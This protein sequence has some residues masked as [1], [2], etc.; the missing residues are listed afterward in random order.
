M[1]AK[2]TLRAALMMAH[3]DVTAECNADRKNGTSR[4]VGMVVCAK[5][6]IHYAQMEHICTAAL[7]YN[8][9]LPEEIE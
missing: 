3:D 7:M 2:E 1:S 5:Y 9:K 4:D 6:G 8:V